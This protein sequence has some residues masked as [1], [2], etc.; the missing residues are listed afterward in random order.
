MNLW[1]ALKDFMSEIALVLRITNQPSSSD[2]I[3]FSQAS[4]NE[5]N[6]N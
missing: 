4:I 5:W 2:E 1:F 6:Y 3:K